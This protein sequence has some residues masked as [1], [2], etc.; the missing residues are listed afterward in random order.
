M[1]DRKLVGS[2]QRSLSRRL[3]LPRR[4]RPLL[5][6][7]ILINKYRGNLRHRYYFHSEFP[8]NKA[9]TNQSERKRFFR[10]SDNDV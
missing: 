7:N 10:G 2:R 9:M 6:G 8:I 3:N 1:H 5:A 4:E